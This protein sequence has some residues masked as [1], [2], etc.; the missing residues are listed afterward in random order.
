[1]TETSGARI[2]SLANEKDTSRALA[3]TPT[4]NPWCYLAFTAVMILNHYIITATLAF[5]V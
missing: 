4:H 2:H 5:P 3:S 1:M